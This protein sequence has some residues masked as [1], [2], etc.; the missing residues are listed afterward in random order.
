MLIMH[1]EID[2]NKFKKGLYIVSTPI[3]NLGDITFRSL[4]VLKN[5][6]YILCED[7]RVTRKLTNH[8]NIK[9]NLISNH[10][11]NEN[12]NIKKVIE[13][14]KSG[15]TISLVSDAGTPTLSD[16][17]RVLV[18]ECVK[19]NINLFPVPG[20]SAITAAVSISGFS[21][22][23]YFNGFVPDKKNEVEKNFQFLSNISSTIVF[24]IS[25][26]KFY[27][28]INQL[29]KHFC[30]RKIVVC[31]EITKYYEEYFRCDVKNLNEKEYNL[32][33]EIT[34]VIS[35]KEKIKKYSE[36]LPESVKS[37]VKKLINKLTIKDILEILNDESK[38]SKSEIYKY[39]LKLKNEK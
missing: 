2:K 8:F 4:E 9:S 34:I 17:G 26:K 7:T 19:E 3:G 16:P 28:I 32:K 10:K 30:D 35:S 24:F 20:A 18:E 33:G 21:N 23:F 14:L 6:K 36:K 38:I 5:S 15:N 1:S 29:K 27:K 12:K 22:N 37:K 25:S 31:K 39:C 11:F 13:L